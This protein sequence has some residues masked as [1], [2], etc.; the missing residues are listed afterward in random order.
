MGE[1]GRPNQPLLIAVVY[2]SCNCPASTYIGDQP[3]LDMD[4]E[5]VIGP[6]QTQTLQY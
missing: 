3:F 6:T 2:N 1:G 5:A 4:I